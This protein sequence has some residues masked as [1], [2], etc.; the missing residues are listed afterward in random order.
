M[1][2]T[3]AIPSTSNPLP[4]PWV[5]RL[6]ERFAAMYGGKFLDLWRDMD[7]AAVKSAWAEDLAGLTVDEIKSG[8]AALKTRPWPPT[9][10]EFIA[11]CRPAIDPRTEWAEACEQMRIRLQ[12]KGLDKWSR[13]Q[14]YWAAVK[15]GQYD[16]QSLSW[17]Q[18]KPRWVYALDNAKADPVPEFHAPLPAPGQTTTTRE[19]AAKRIIEIS[20]KT[21][22]KA[23]NGQPSTK[24]AVALA[25]REAGGEDLSHIQKTWWREALGAPHETSAKDFLAGMEKKAA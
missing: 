19:K 5:E 2:Q 15:I 22:I 1:E 3:P 18:I 21:G 25:E 24:W 11:L 8:L 6:F 17:D 13:P 10:P 14:V 9:L 20:D 12:G 4:L 7:V 16:L 23:A